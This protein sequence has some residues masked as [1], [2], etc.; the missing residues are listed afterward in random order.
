MEV[1]P[2]AEHQVADNPIRGLSARSA[3]APLCGLNNRSTESRVQGLNAPSAD[4]PKN[5]HSDAQPLDAVLRGPDIP[6]YSPD[7]SFRIPD[8]QLVEGRIRTPDVQPLDG[9]IRSPAVQPAEPLP[10]A[11]HPEYG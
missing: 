11:E 9:A 10:R 5:P 3:D 8:V 6:P 4:P 2:R 7:V 1:P